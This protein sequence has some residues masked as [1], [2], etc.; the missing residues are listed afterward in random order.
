MGVQALKFTSLLNRLKLIGANA[1]LSPPAPV[2]WVWLFG[3]KRG[4][5]P[6]S[7]GPIYPIKQRKGDDLI[8]ALMIQKILK[9]LEFDASECA[10]FW[11]VTEHERVPDQ[12]A[13]SC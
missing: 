4:V 12:A 6:F 8:P 7:K 5:F 2:G 1:V 3:K 11:G 9:V 10:Q 13:K